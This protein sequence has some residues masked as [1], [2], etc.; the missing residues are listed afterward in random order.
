MDGD[1]EYLASQ[2]DI[3]QIIKV[4]NSYYNI[5]DEHELDKNNQ[6]QNFV[7]KA[8]DIRQKASK[9]S[10]TTVAACSAAINQVLISSH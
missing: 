2:Y 10:L 8:Q 5:T 1:E 3:G 7:I 9:Q 6:F 4:F